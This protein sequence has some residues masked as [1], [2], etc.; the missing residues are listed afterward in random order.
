MIQN[1]FT[2]EIYNADF[3]DLCENV[4][5]SPEVKAI[6]QEYKGICERFLD[7]SYADNTIKRYYVYAWFAKTVPPRYF[8][9]GKGTGS[10]YNHILS[11]IKKYKNG[12]QNMRFQ[13]YSE[14]Q[15][16][17][18]IDYK[19]IISGLTEYEAL[20]YEECL[21]LKYLEQ[22]EILLNVEGV[23]SE[24]LPEGWYAVPELT[25][26]NIYKEPFYDK[27]YDDHSLPFFDKVDDES[28]LKTYIYPYFVDEFENIIIA[29]RQLITD[30]LL[31]N[32]AK[33]YKTVSKGTRSII[34]QGSLMYDRYTF[35]RSDGKKIYSSKDVLEYI[36]KNPTV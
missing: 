31:R 9:V 7:L 21:K 36:Q 33:I 4:V 20:I 15:D 8:Y 10:R 35:Y 6:Y 29:D 1:I 30:W 27:Y 23:P 25:G 28:L 16:R 24:Y 19:I 12:K 11:D 26:P 14:I 22:G 5:V 18:G 34:I 2:K 13:H 32:N 3:S 17:L